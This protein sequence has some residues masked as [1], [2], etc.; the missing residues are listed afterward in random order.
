MLIGLAVQ[1]VVG[2]MTALSMYREH[3]DDLVTHAACAGVQ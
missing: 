2:D 3:A 1:R